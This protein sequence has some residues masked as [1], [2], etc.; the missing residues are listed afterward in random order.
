MTRPLIL[1]AI[2]AALL[3]LVIGFPPETG[4]LHQWLAPIFAGTI[5]TSGH[6]E[7]AYNF[8][9]I[10]GALAI[11]TTALVA[12]AI[13][14]AWR[15]FGVD[16]PALRLHAEPRPGSRPRP[17]ARRRSSPNCI[18]APPQSGGSTT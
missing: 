4:L 13:V 18:E 12:V 10:D 6:T 1:L 11:A 5:A 14:V 15:L 8:F 9:G 7:A 16:V 3:G 2:P 17:P